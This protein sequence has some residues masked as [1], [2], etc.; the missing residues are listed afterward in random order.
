MKFGLKLCRGPQG[1]GHIAS[2]AIT[3]V[4]LGLVVGVATVAHAASP[5]LAPARIDQPGLQ[6]RGEQLQVIYGGSESTS[7]LIQRQQLADG[8]RLTV[9]ATTARPQRPF[10]RPGH[11]RA[12]NPDGV[13]L[14]SWPIAAGSS[15][16]GPGLRASVANGADV[17]PAVAQTV[18][19][20]F[21]G[22]TLS[23]AGAFPPD[24]MGTV[25]PTQFL[26]TIN[27]RFRVYSK[28]GVAGT[29]NVDPDVFFASVVTPVGGSVVFSF[30]SD[31][32]VRYDRLTG[33]WYIVMIDVPCTNNTCSTTAANRVMIAVSDGPTISSGTVWSFFSFVGDPGTNFVDYPTLGVDANAL[34]IGGN[35]FSSAGSFVG[36]NGYVVQKSSILG[37]G[38]VV[39]TRFANLAAGSSSGPFTPQGVDNFDASPTFGYFIGV[40]NALFSTLVLRRVSNPGSV[41]PTLSADISLSVPTTTFPTPQAHQGNTGGNNGRLDS[42][43]D[44]LF[45]AAIRGGTLWTAHNIRVGA[46]GVASTAAQARNAARWYQLGSNLS[47]AAA[48]PTL[49]QSGTLFDNAATLALARGYWI[50]TVMVSGQGHMAIGTS[51]AGAAFFADAFTTGRLSGDTLGTLQA[52]AT[53]TSTAAAYNPGSDPGGSSGR[54]WGDYSYTSVDPNDD[55]T[56]W[57]IQEYT[58]AANIWGT[59]IAKMLAPPPAAPTAVAPASV[60][61]GQAGVN[62]VVTGASSAGSGFFDPGAGFANRIQ[63]SV[64]GTNV[65]VNSVTYTNPTSITLNLKTTGAAAGNRTITVTNPDGQSAS[66]GAI[67]TIQAVVCDVNGDGRVDATDLG[68]IRAMSGQPVGG[69]NAVFDANGDGAINVADLRYCQLRL[70]PP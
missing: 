65:I 37:G 55:M 18:V 29:F 8:Q 5:Q 60:L 43:D 33:R 13:E 70:T 26:V 46:T 67:L 45:A 28:T 44:R 16:S 54:R 11:D 58:A 20:T 17:V 61:S 30:T 1:L 35:I 19:T 41:A 23:D 4:A 66:S 34:Y 62:V 51:T 15:V 48:A 25:G 6:I 52:G 10:L 21:D 42:L 3:A 64:S 32:R 57:T 47:Q 31:P 9:G 36:T 49:L 22:P 53:Y 24:T 50:P 40:D 59:K 7:A 2:V 14:S 39:A 38:P 69:A 63:A 27:G 56:L 68:L 12:P